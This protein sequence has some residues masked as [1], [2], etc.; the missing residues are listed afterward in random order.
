MQMNIYRSRRT[1]NS[2]TEATS[3][4]GVFETISEVLQGIDGFAEHYLVNMLSSPEPALVVC[5]RADGEPIDHGWVKLDPA[6][7]RLFRD[8]PVGGWTA[9]PKGSARHFFRDVADAGNYM[10]FIIAN[11]NR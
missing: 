7:G 4:A 1:A 2:P 9:G 8:Y 5:R 10:S 6:T 11:R 3:S